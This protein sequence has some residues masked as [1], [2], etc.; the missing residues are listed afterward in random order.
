MSVSLWSR[1]LNFQLNSKMICLDCNSIKILCRLSFQLLKIIKR[2]TIE[3]WKEIIEYLRESF[4]NF[5]G[6][7][8]VILKVIPTYNQYLIRRRSLRH[9][10]SGAL[11]TLSCEFDL[12][13]AS[14]PSA[15]KFHASRLLLF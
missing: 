15:T 5:K 14:L 13:Y 12:I 10:Q 8:L 2:F 3:W 4:L 11:L 1:M 7:S 9:L 6:R